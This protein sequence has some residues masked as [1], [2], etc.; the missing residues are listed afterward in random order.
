MTAL[1][2]APRYAVDPKV[3][4][5]RARLQ[6]AR[7]ASERPDERGAAKLASQHKLP[8]RERIAL[9]F[10]DGSFVEDGRYAN[11][12]ADRLPADGVVTG[13]GTVDGRPAMVVA[14]D[15][16]VK[17]GS[18]GAR[19]VEKIVRATEHALREELP[20]F[21]FVDSAG[22]RITDQVDLFPGRRGAGR[23]FHNQVA[24][25]G[26]VPQICCLFGPSAAGGAYIPAF[27]DCVIMVEGNASM[28]LGSPRMAEMVVGEKVSLEE[29]GGA[30]MHCTVSGC[31]DLLAS[32][33]ADA[34]EQARLLLSYLPSTWRDEPP[35]YV[36]E[37]PLT[38]LDASVVPEVESQPFDVHE[39]LDGLLDEDSFFEVKPL[40]AAELVT[41]FGRMDGRTVGVVAN[42]SA[43]KGGVLFADSADKAARFIWWCDAFNVPLLYLADV[44]GF[45]I[46]SDVERGGIIRHGAKMVSAVSEATVPQISVVVRKAY[47]AGLYA[48][49]GP[50]FGPD[51]CLALPTARIA[52]MGPEAA[53]NAV[54]AN[55]IEAIADPDERAAFVADRRAEYEQ[56]VD[57]ER[58]V[59]DLVLDGVVEPEDLRA[60]LLHRFRYAARRD[61]AFTSRRRGVPPV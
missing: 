12:L 38:P 37:P 54:Y 53:V 47:G 6:A 20:V 24:L 7:E 51:A 39:V 41:G 16:T 30:R 32:D 29:M 1:A 13:R 14:N 22:A 9:L 17:A 50:G 11:A 28:Y 10:D 36:P 57:L 56:D 23:I 49:A 19:T 46:G 45:M 34:I 2:R 15:P 25:S 52:V 8:V 4:D 31:G 35:T 27:T 33:D 3:A 59:S 43:V 55:K 58:L 26:R 44:P 5:V 42:N 40:F 18:W 48:M 61:R 21:W 60:E